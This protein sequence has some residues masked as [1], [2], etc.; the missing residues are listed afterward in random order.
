[1]RCLW[2]QNAGEKADALWYHV[3]HHN[4]VIK[5]HRP[6]Q[7]SIFSSMESA[8]IYQKLRDNA[9]MSKFD[10]KMTYELNSDAIMS[11]FCREYLDEIRAAELVPFE[12]KLDAVVFLASNCND[13]SGR[14]S[15]VQK[16]MELGVPVHARGNCLKNMEI[17]PRSIPNVK[18]MRN[19]K[20]CITMEN[21]RAQDYV[22]EKLFEAMKAGCLPIYYGAP[23]IEDFIPLSSSI[24]DYQKLGSPEALAA[25]I[26]QLMHNKTAYE[27]HFRYKK[28]PLKDLASRYLRTRSLVD[29]IYGSEC[30]MCMV[31]AKARA[32]KLEQK[33]KTAK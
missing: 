18:I 13:Q 19:Y 3:P 9:Y 21:S 6:E 4:D 31:I 2:N 15:I 20:F 24:I 11:Y 12:K 32:G 29:S 23:N 16:L 28:M 5:K 26:N 22:S 17:S 1:M 10:L 8:D 14:K 25:K 30:R 27:H 7:L 33:W